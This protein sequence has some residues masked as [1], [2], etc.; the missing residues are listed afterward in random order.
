M[1]CATVRRRTPP[2]VSMTLCSRPFHRM[3]F[4][5]DP[6][7]VVH[8]A[9]TFTPNRTSPRTRRDAQFQKERYGQMPRPGL[10]PQQ[11]PGR[12]CSGGRQRTSPSQGSAACFEPLESG[13]PRHDHVQARPSAA[14]APQTRRDSVPSPA[15]PRSAPRDGAVDA[16]DVSSPP[17]WNAMLASTCSEERSVRSACTRRR[18]SARR[19]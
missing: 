18:S 11:V 3:P 16:I 13:R 1:A 4:S 10:A 19:P 17:P 7:P 9:P 5:F 15:R 8:F 14:A 12:A 2:E 6:V